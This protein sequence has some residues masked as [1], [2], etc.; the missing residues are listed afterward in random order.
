M[1][2]YT[3]TSSIFSGLPPVVD[4]STPTHNLGARSYTADGRAYRY[5]LAGGTALVTGNLIQGPAED[6]G[7]VELEFAAE[8]VGA[9]SLV[10]T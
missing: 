1:S 8:A 10:A 2:V 7:D 3:G 9:T 4:E 5:V 6:T